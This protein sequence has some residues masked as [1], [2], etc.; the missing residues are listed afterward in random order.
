MI[1][2]TWQYILAFK[3]EVN[4]MDSMRKIVLK[5]YRGLVLIGFLQ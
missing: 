4:N 5:S 1:G 3:I 2:I